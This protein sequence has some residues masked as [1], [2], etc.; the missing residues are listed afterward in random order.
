MKYN[1]AEL[2]PNNYNKLNTENKKIK[3]LNQI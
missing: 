1:K 2:D 3:I